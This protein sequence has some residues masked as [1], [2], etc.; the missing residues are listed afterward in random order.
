MKRNGSRRISCPSPE[1][2]AWHEFTRDPETFFKR[3]VVVTVKLPAGTHADEVRSVVGEISARHEIFRTS[4]Q[5]RAEGPP[6]TCCHSAIERAYF[7]SMDGK[8]DAGP[9][10]GQ[11]GASSA[12][13]TCSP[14]WLDAALLQGEAAADQSPAGQIIQ[15]SHAKEV[16]QTGLC[17]NTQRIAWAYCDRS[18]PLELP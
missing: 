1:L 11:G 17:A 3:G 7:F 9:C 16:C 18:R 4:Y 15:R 10:L 5:A 14:R 2:S 13:V 12:M 6:A 8:Y